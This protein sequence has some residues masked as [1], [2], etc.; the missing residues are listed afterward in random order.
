MKDAKT[1]KKGL[2]NTAGGLIQSF[3]IDIL[4]PVGD[5]C[6]GRWGEFHLDNTPHSKRMLP[7]GTIGKS[8]S[9]GGSDTLSKPQRR[10][11]KCGLTK[12]ANPVRIE[13]RKRKRRVRGR[14]A[15]KTS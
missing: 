10:G 13:Y 4:S 1:A 8:A 9:G 7:M 11:K 2:E 12:L 5:V 15:T 3:A 14:G 6:G